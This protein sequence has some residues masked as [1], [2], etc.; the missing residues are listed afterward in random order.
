MKKLLI[1]G[2]APIIN[3]GFGKVVKNLVDRLKKHYKIAILGINYQGNI[4]YNTKEYFI[5]PVDKSDIYGINK[6]QAAV[7]DFKPDLIFLLQDIHLIYSL[8]VAHEDIFEQIPTVI[9]FPVD[10]APFSKFWFPVLNKFKKSLVLSEYAKKQIGYSGYDTSEIEVLYHGVDTSV[11]KP[12]APEEV[13][14]LREYA[15]WD[16][17]FM[18]TNVNRFNPRKHVTQTLRIASMFILGYRKCECGNV[19]PAHLNECDL[20]GCSLNKSEFIPGHDDAAIYLHMIID[21]R[22][23]GNLPTD[24]LTSH[25]MLNGFSTNLI[26]DKIYYNVRNIYGK[27]GIAETE[28][29]EIMNASNVIISTTLGEGFGLTTAEAIACGANVIIGNNTTHN[30]L[31]NNGKFGAIVENDAVITLGSDTGVS[32]PIMS[33]KGALRELELL[34]DYWKSTGNLASEVTRANRFNWISRTFNW[35]DIGDQLLNILKEAE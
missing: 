29:A 13:T 21:D 17:K 8:Q 18:I 3:T 7:D 19:Y 1:W 34:Y 33:T 10:G 14:K 11:F 6:F 24:F 31:T 9:Y 5:Y 16:K 22:L 2:D 12:I 35:D 4:A 15:G 27:N 26:N 23:M 32:R 25:A 28:V 20:N 30:E